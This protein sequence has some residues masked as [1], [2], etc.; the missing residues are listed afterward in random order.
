MYYLYSQQFKP[1]RI[2][3][4]YAT[5]NQCVCPEVTP[6]SMYVRNEHILL[7]IMMISER[8]G[9]IKQYLGCE[10]HRPVQQLSFEKI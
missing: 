10:Q 8:N 9:R 2:R 3:V 7:L 5:G 1:V 4:I 6:N